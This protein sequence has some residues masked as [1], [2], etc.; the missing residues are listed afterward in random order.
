VRSLQRVWLVLPCALLVALGAAASPA[1]AQVTEPSAVA[2]WIEFELNAIASH[3]TNPPRA[4]RALA[5]VSAAM[6]K[7]ARTGG[8]A[9]DDAVAGAASTVLVYLYPDQAAPIQ[10]LAGQV[11]DVG[12]KGFAHGQ[13]IG[14]AQVAHAQSDRSDNVF[15]GSI[16]AGPGFWVP[17]PPAFIQSPL[18]PLAGTW[19]TWNLHKGSQFR[20]GPPPAYGSAAFVDEVQEVYE[21]SQTLT[22]DQKRIAEFWADGPQTVTPPGHWNRIALDL[23]RAA[24]WP[25]LRASLL[26]A[27]LN[28]AQADAFIACW[29]AKYTYW[30]MRPVTAIRDPRFVHDSKARG[31]LSYIVTPPFPSYVSGHSTTSGAAST[32]LAAFFPQQA[33]ELRAMAE[34]AGASRL[35]GGIHFRSDNEAGLE[36]GRRVGAVALDAYRIR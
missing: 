25:T 26:F 16:P 18:E 36:L 21:V 1:R 12:G 31:W 33:G 23:V 13:V 10:A 27:A 14:R 3:A 34:E 7:A 35:Y 17:T 22:D 11:A 5:N 20:P 30:S 29:D 4:A 28:T 9:P 24:G 32:V 2:P 19:R 8:G 6:Y 15:A